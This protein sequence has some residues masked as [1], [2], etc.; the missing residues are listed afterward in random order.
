MM[1]LSRFIRPRCSKIPDVCFSF[2]F[3]SVAPNIGICG[4][5]RNSYLLNYL[6]TSFFGEG[7]AV[8][9]PPLTHFMPLVSFDTP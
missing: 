3:P 5:V 9:I 7:L 2:S 8:Y 1:T 4:V 6:K